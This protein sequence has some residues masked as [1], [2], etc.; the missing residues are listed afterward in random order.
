MEPLPFFPALAAYVRTLHDAQ[1]KAVDCRRAAAS[2]VIGDGVGICGRDS[3]ASVTSVPLFDL[4]S[5]RFSLSP[6][7]STKESASE[8]SK[9]TPNAPSLWDDICCRPRRNSF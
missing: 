2:R 1:T 4:P 3:H 5:L 8:V 9:R 7:T 6:S